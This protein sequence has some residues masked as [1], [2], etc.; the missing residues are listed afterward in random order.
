MKSGEDQKK[1]F[2]ENGSV[3]SS[4]SDEDQQKK[5]DFAKN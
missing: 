4:K 5:K 3:L 2:A 1:V